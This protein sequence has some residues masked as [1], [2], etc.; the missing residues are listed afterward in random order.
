MANAEMQRV[1]AEMTAIAEHVRG[2]STK[3][4]RLPK[5]RKQAL[6]GSADKLKKRS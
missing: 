1:L 6:Q 2:D 5:E 4:N 3:F